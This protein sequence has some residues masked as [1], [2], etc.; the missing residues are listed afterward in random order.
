MPVAVAFAFAVAA[1]VVAVVA[2]A[3]ACGVV[4]LSLVVACACV[5]ARVCVC[6][7]RGV[8]GWRGC[9]GFGLAAAGL[10]WARPSGGVGCAV[11]WG[12]GGV[13]WFSRA[14]RLPLG[15]AR[16]FSFSR[17]VNLYEMYP[18]GAPLD[19]IPSPRAQVRRTSTRTSARGTCPTCAPRPPCSRAP[20]PST[21]TWHLRWRQVLR[22]RRR[23]VG[24]GAASRRTRALPHTS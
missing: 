5:R 15:V 20:S 19:P 18:F 23:V 1:A 10:H 4:R 11:G 16:V 2:V 14:I 9:G 3:V 17:V 12:C 21:R 6:V 22:R 8:W 7:G 13:G 24:Q